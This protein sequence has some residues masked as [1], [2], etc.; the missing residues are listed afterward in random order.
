MLIP[1]QSSWLRNRW[2]VSA[3]VICAIL[4]WIDTWRWWKEFRLHQQIANA[5]HQIEQACQEVHD[6]SK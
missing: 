5:I 6:K 3:L 4:A 1:F 2:F